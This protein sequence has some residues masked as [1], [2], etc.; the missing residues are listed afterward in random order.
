[1]TSRAQAQPVWR[2][3][4]VIDGRPRLQLHPEWGHISVLAG[5][6]LS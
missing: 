6:G 1:M 4:N 2:D 5:G 3:N